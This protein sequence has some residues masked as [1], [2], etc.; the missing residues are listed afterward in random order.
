MHIYECLKHV[1]PGVNTTVADFIHQV[2]YR[3]I[4]HN[5]IWYKWKQYF[6]YYS[7]LYIQCV[8]K[9]TEIDALHN[10]RIY[11]NIYLMDHLCDDLSNIYYIMFNGI[12]IRITACHVNN[13]EWYYDTSIDNKSL[14][15]IDSLDLSNADKQW[16]KVTLA[17][18]MLA[19]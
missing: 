12:K 3:P 10:P 19:K 17:C 7:D 2:Q 8:G 4:Y 1:L 14:D 11:C 15:V 13:N 6:S 5:T 9:H 18:D 16:L